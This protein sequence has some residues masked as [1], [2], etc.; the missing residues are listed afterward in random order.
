MTTTES[1]RLVPLGTREGLVEVAAFDLEGWTEF[2]IGRN[3]G[4]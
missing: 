3:G 4:R 2:Q 1:E